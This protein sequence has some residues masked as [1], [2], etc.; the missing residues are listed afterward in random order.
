MKAQNGLAGIVL[1]IIGAT[2]PIN[3]TIA[4]LE[5]GVNE[6]YARSPVASAGAAKKQPDAQFWEAYKR[7]EPEKATR[8]NRQR[9]TSS[10][11]TILAENME[12]INDYDVSGIKGEQAK[13]LA[14]AFH[15]Y[16]IA[17]MRT[18]KLEESYHSALLA[19]T[20]DQDQ[21]IIVSLAG[22]SYRT[23]RFDQTITLV[24]EYE[25]NGFTTRLPVMQKLAERAKAAKELALR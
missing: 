7:L 8:Y 14:H 16:G 11:M 13:R 18:N 10:A 22:A 12:I 2:A 19:Y 21:E 3:P 6:A 25:S 23:N 9:Q 4:N 1:G 5:V 20:L 24:N 15:E 17:L